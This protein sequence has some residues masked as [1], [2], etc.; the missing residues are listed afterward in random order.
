MNNLGQD[1]IC[2]K[3]IRKRQREKE[4]QAPVKPVE[5]LGD[6]KPERQDAD[7]KDKNALEDPGQKIH[8]T[9]YITDEYGHGWRL[10]V[11]TQWKVWTQGS[12]RRSKNFPGKPIPE[13]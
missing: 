4:R 10:S 6:D 1:N 9:Q 13:I 3:K 7:K 8:E 5:Y 12:C 2:G 11:V